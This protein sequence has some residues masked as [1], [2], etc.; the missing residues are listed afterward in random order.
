M[1]LFLKGKNSELLESLKTKMDAAT[2][3]FRYEEAAVYRDKIKAVFV[4]CLIQ[5]KSNRLSEVVT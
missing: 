4:L 3:E 2:L 5:L 1:I